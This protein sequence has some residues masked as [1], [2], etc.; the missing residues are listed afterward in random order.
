MRTCPDS[1]DARKDD[2]APSR[3]RHHAT[4]LIGR[5]R[6]ALVVIALAALATP[7][8]SLGAGGATYQNPLEPVIP[9]D[10][11]VESCADPSVIR[12][13][14]G[15]GRWYLYCTTDPLNDE[16]RLPDGS[17]RFHLIPMLSSADLVHWTYEGDAFPTRPAYATPTAGLWAPE[18]VHHPETGEYLLYYTVTDTTL[19]GGGSAIG[20]AS[21][22]SP[23]GPWTD[24]GTPAVE[25]HGADCCG[26]DSRRWV[27]DPDVLRTDGPDYI[28]YGS[29]FGGISVRQLSEDGLTSDPA[30]QS[31]VAIANKFEGAEVVV[32]GGYY[33]L[34]ASA[35]NCC[36]GPQ[37]GYSVFVGRSTSPVGPFV[38]R[39]GVP[40]NDNEDTVDPTDP[41]DGRAGGTVALSMSGNRWV[42][43]GHNTVFQDLAGQW[44]TI[45]HAVDVTDPYFEGAVGFTKR[46][47]LMDRIE[48][49]DGWPYVRG[50]RFVSDTPQLAP[51][52][53]PGDRPTPAEPA[54]REDALGAALPAFSDAFAGAALDEAW[55]WVRPPDAGSYSVS[56]GALHMETQDADL[57]VDS[58]N[59]SVLTRPAPD[60]N[61]VV[62]TKVR[63]SVPAEGCCWNYVQAGLVLYEND[64]SFIKLTTVSIWNTRQTEFAREVET[65]PDG[66]PRYGNTVVGP[67]GEWTWLR[68]VVRT[69]GSG[70]VDGPYGGTERYTAYTSHDGATWTRGGTW[71]GDLGDDARIGLVAMGGGGF[72]ADFDGVTVSRLHR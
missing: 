47:A 12:G 17:L 58:N 23:L 51:A 5:L 25:P 69:D 19:P 16:D 42:G 63:L 44:W 13:Q 8:A 31:N 14:E 28:Y 9:G 22:P 36:A 38:D 53:Q 45:Y 32:R 62:E 71:A 21:A 43:P 46:P 29:Y 24:S 34:F 4:H 2:S 11:V 20:V 52:A 49:I 55:S 30:T 15:E 66:Y 50:G 60:G 70:S 68:I 56:G 33:Y 3:Q 57:F 61:Y 72:T 26:P 37:T 39:E 64:D 6:A 41:T 18:I 35:T 59:A 27:F 40:L 65:V 54:L 10:D 67:P 48:W 1:R 7:T